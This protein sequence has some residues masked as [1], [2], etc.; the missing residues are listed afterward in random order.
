MSPHELI[1]KLIDLQN[2][3]AA[4]PRAIVT[5]ER[6][7]HALAS[8][9][10]IIDVE[11]EMLREPLIEHVGHLP[12]IA[13]FLHP[14]IEHSKDV[15]LGRVLTM[16]SIHDIGETVLGDTLTY[17]KNK[18][19]TEEENEVARKLLNRAHIP[20]FEEF[21]L[22]ESFDAKFAKSVDAMAPFLHEIDKPKLTRKRFVHWKFNSKHIEA[23]KR[24]LF[25]WDA[26]LKAMF[27]EYL[28]AFH[29]IERGEPTGFVTTSVD[30][31]EK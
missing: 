22:R 21:E 2:G 31:A 15:D 18:K 25:E 24:P 20:L 11:D 3:Y 9:A 7:R 27:R 1:Q 23:K 17:A 6:L 8:M 14:H 4:V 29:F 26:V 19:Q 12:I 30:M 10:R 13:S 5:G 28:A 16:L